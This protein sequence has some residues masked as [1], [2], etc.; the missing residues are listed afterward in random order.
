MHG[1]NPDNHHIV[2]RKLHS[3]DYS[4]LILFTLQ[5]WMR[6]GTPGTIREPWGSKNSHIKSGNNNGNFWSNLLIHFESYLH[7]H[8]R[9]TNSGYKIGKGKV[10]SIKYLSIIIF[11]H[12]GEG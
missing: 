9:Y 8:K 5:K 4:N 11:P 10:R 2:G 7:N 3:L 12:C 1:L 6:I